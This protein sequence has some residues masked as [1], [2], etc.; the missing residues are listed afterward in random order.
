MEEVTPWVAL[1]CGWRRQ[2]DQMHSWAVDWDYDLVYSWGLG[3]ELNNPWFGLH[4]ER[5][6]PWDAA[7]V[8]CFYPAPFDPRTPAWGKHFV[9]YVH[10]ANGIR[11]LGD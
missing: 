1:A 5:Y 3:R 6:A 8:V 2:T 9:A 7:K 4:P 10:G 11:K